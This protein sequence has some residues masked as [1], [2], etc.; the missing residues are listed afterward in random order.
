[1]IKSTA[2]YENN[3]SLLYNFF[4]FES[5][6]L[7]Q[8]TFPNLCNQCMGYFNHLQVIKVCGGDDL[9]ASWPT[10]AMVI[11][12]SGNTEAINLSPL[13]FGKF[14]FGNVMFSVYFLNEML[15]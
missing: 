3:G 5:E 11:P 4:K 7:H 1:M 9:A 13:R 8:Y 14:A 10:Q 15:P 2:A 12:L 6:N